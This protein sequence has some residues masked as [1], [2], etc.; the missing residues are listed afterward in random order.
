MPCHA[1]QQPRDAAQARE[2]GRRVLQRRLVAA[3]N[4]LEDSVERAPWDTPPLTPAVGVV[5]PP[6]HRST[7]GGCELVGVAALV[8]RCPQS[9]V[10]GVVLRLLSRFLRQ[11][12][13]D[14]RDLTAA[15][16]GGGMRM[17]PTLSLYAPGTR[18]SGSAG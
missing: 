17:P 4:V 8:V 6:W 7:V 13:M 16:G 1:P 12:R 11:G 9:V 2:R 15:F 18:M 3:L 10:V 14:P 5:A